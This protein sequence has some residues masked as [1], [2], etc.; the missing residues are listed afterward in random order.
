MAG[1]A[2]PRGSGVKKIPGQRDDP[3]TT[4]DC[5]GPSGSPRSILAT[6]DVG[7]QPL[8]LIRSEVRRRL[9]E[10]GASGE[11]SMA[12]SCLLQDNAYCG[13]RFMLDGFQAV[14]FL[15]ENEVKFYAP[16]GELLGGESL[17]AVNRRTVSK[18]A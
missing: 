10:F 14:W 6:R 17:G 18:A 16:G 15:E 3:Y 5:R 1:Q 9:A 13:R 11:E 12:E 8:E 2:G 7:V 4:D